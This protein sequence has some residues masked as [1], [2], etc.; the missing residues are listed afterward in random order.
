MELSLS[1]IV[2]LGFPSQY[3]QVITLGICKRVV[4]HLD[5]CNGADVSTGASPA[6]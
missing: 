1:G 2:N 3:E 4:S 5:T 6:F